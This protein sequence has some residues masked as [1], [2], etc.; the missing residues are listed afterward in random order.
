MPAPHKQT[1]FISHSSLDQGVTTELYQV[2]TGRYKLAC[3]MDAFDLHPDKGPF[4]EQI[5]KALRN[6]SILVL[7]DSPAGRSSD[8]VNREIQLGKDLRLPIQRC[9]ID[10]QLPAWR[11]KMRIQRLALGIQLRL[12]RGFLFAALSLFVLL[13]ALATM[14]FFLG[15]QVVPA[16]AR[17]GRDLP[18]PFRPTP[19]LTT[20]PQPSDPKMAAPFHFKP[21][22]V[23]LQDDFDN[24]TFENS[25]NDHT[26]TYDI[27]PRDPLV[28]T[29]QQNGSLV[30]SFPAECLNTEKT[31]DCELE[32]D[33]NVLEA[34]AIQYFGMR[35]R[36]VERTS[37][38]DVSV[39][40]SINQPQR[41]R[42]GFGWDFTDHAMAFFRSIPTLPE[43]D[44]YAYVKIDPG[45]HA[46]E[47]VHNTQNARFDYYVDGQ[48]VATFTLVHAQEWNQ[49]PLRLIIYSLSA[50]NENSGEKTATR[51]EIDQV[52]I[53]GFKGR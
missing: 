51:F 37:L 29:D 43:K 53:G 9:S 52:I 35:A 19:T 40:I 21:D 2:L 46:Y 4:S 6:S 30:I 8:Y 39:S 24:Q 44:L 1:I 32:L 45:W 41:S 42:A 18:A 34:S 38:R 48:L 36:T 28:K 23:L 7:V 22:T 5:V 15:T 11:R 50:Q 16:L 12:A 27:K 33:S 3:W 25:I 17:A 31:W 13:A 20:A 49:A 14:I 10:E 47:I 26:M